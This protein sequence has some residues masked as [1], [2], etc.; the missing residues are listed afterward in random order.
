MDLKLK[1]ESVSTSADSVYR[2]EVEVIGVAAKDIIEQL[3]IEDIIRYAG[4]DNLLDEI[5]EEKAL[6]H[7]E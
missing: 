2:M 7:F 3:E 5:G 1:A 4:V 6:K